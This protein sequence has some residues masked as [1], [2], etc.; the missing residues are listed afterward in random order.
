[1]DEPKKEGGMSIWLI[2]IICVVI[3]IVVYFLYVWLSGTTI[4]ETTK[5]IVKDGRVLLRDGWV[6]LKDLDKG[7]CLTKSSGGEP[8]L[9]KC[10]NQ[11]EQKWQIDSKARLRNYG[12]QEYCLYPMSNGDEG[13]DVKIGICEENGYWFLESYPR[14][15]A[16]FRFMDN[17]SKM[18]LTPVKTDPL[19]LTM[20]KC[21]DDLAQYYIP[22]EI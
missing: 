2:M 3:V 8:I 15:I 14:S 21:E 6:Y 12:D 9:I 5:P 19:G 4:E 22:T 13:A 16:Q 10:A 1:M 11:N 18:C 17:R 20:A 7:F